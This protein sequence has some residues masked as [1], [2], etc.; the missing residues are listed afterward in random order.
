MQDSAFEF[1]SFDQFSSEAGSTGSAG[2][3]AVRFGPGAT[4]VL[5]GDSHTVGALGGL[6]RLLKATG[7]S[8]VRSAQKGTAVKQWLG[9][10]PPLLKKHAPNIV[11]VA[12]GANMRD[13]PYP[14]AT[15]AQ[16]TKLIAAIRK[17][18]PGAALYWIGPPRKRSDTTATLAAFN[19][20]LKNGLGSSTRFVDH[21]RT[22][23]STKEA[24]G[25]LYAP[26][27]SQALGEEGVFVELHRS[28]AP[29]KAPGW[30]RS[31]AR[32]APAN[33]PPRRP[34][35]SRSAR[36]STRTPPKA[37]ELRL[38]EASDLRG[39]RRVTSRARQAATRSGRR[40]SGRCSML[41]RSASLEQL[42]SGCSAPIRRRSVP[43]Q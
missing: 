7:A 33:A 27:P 4:V 14:R 19:A 9:R 29:S 12:L 11:I 23:R 6:E 41:A 21:R 32:S 34:R 5:V 43:A 28:R 31:A 22:L 36:S 26:G 35:A 24:S 25:E 8:M 17:E 40:C 10:L 30:R 2:A 20:I 38:H 39:G 1:E 3:S 15:S 42:C 18:R 37:L 13:Y 16:V